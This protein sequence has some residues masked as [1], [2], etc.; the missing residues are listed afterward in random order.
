MLIKDA[1]NCCNY[2]TSATDDSMSTEHWLNDIEREY[3]SARTTTCPTAT[4]STQIP[5]AVAFDSTP[6]SVVKDQQLPEHGT[7]LIILLGPKLI[8]PQIVVPY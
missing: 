8:T 5:H 7:D 2:I 1:V 4:L 6:I 3:R